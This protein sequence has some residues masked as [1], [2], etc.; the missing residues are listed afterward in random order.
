VPQNSTTFEDLWHLRNRTSGDEINLETAGIVATEKLASTFDIKIGDYLLLSKQDTLG[1]ATDEVY[2]V[3]VGAIAENYIS[4]DVFMT[5]GAYERIFGK[6]PAYNTIYAEISA[7]GDVRSSFA[8]DAR[9]IEGVKTVA[10]NDETID[11]YKTA[12]KSVDMV[13][14]VLI[15]AAALLAAIVLY[16]LTNININE[17]MREIATLKVLG[18]TRRE[19]FNYV[20]REILILAII[21]AAVGLV[22]GVALENFVVVTAEVDAVMFGRSIHV[23]SFVMA[24]V[25]T[26]VFAMV[27]SL[28]MRG[29]LHRI[30]MVESLKSIE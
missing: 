28:L 29:K 24:F 17:R 10:F 18:F 5:V 7:S 27:I 8:A 21:G 23:F 26:V 19:V 16:N 14:I 13:V 25:L 1:N 4:H 15:V 9:E 3:R 20:F 12:L 11:M 2:A 22:L 30:D 6:T